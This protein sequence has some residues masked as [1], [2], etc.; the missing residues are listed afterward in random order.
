MVPFLSSTAGWTPV[1]SARSWSPRTMD[2]LP[3][4]CFGS[5]DEVTT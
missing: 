5:N 1:I 2:R 3:K 4:E